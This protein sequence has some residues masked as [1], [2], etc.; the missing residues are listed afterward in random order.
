MSQFQCPEKTGNFPAVFLRSI[1]ARAAGSGVS[2]GKTTS[3]ASIGHAVDEGGR[4]WVTTKIEGFNL[5]V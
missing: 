5:M 2:G 3:C 4:K 1:K